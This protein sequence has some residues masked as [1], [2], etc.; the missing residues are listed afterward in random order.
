V[1]TLQDLQSTTIGLTYF[2][3]F[4]VEGVRV[5]WEREVAAGYFLS[6]ADVVL[7]LLR[8]DLSALRSLNKGRQG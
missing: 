8:V 2:F 3:F 7:L 5:G 6:M 1:Y 4:Q